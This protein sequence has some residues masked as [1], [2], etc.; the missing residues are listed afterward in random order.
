MN[1][2]QEDRAFIKFYQNEA[3]IEIR[4]EEDGYRILSGEM[5]SDI[6]KEIHDAL[7]N[8]NGLINA[9][10]GKILVIL[11]KYAKDESNGISDLIEVTVPFKSGLWSETANNFVIFDT[12]GSNSASNIDHAQVLKKAME[13]MSNGMPIFVSEYN[14]LDSTDNEKLY[15]DIKAI[16]ELDSRFTMIIVNKADEADLEEEEGRI[17]LPLNRERRLMNLAIP[18]NMFGEGVFFVSSVM[19]LGAKVDGKLINKHYLRLFSRNKDEYADP[20]DDLYQRLYRFNIMPEQLKNKAVEHAEKC[21]DLIYANSGLYSVEKEIQTFGDKYSSYNKCFQSETFLR[22]VIDI[23]SDEI[24]QSKEKREISKQNRLNALERDK[25]ELIEIID[26]QDKDSTKQFIDEYPGFMQEYIDEAKSTSYEESLL[27]EK[28]EYT[29][30]QEKELKLEDYVNNADEAAGAIFKNFKDS[31]KKAWVNKSFDEVKKAG[32]SFFDDLYSAQDQ[33]FELERVRQ[34][35]KEKSDDMIIEKKNNDY[36]KYSIYAQNS[37]NDH[38]K[39]YWDQKAKEIKNILSEIVTGSAALTEE[40]REK[41]SNIIISYQNIDFDSMQEDLI[42]KKKFEK[43]LFLGKMTVW[44][45]GE[46]NLKK[47]RDFYN[48]EI[49]LK[50]NKTYETVKESHKVSFQK[51]IDDLQETITVNIVEFNPELYSQNELI[52]E[53]TEK[54]H[55]LESRQITLN[56][57]RDEIGGKM[58]WKE[59]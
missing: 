8:N 28:E 55:E 39:E 20:M 53:E 17:G 47:L 18:K 27:D 46:V 10:M 6:V 26:K 43:G 16:E 15:K 59:G 35:I 13:D 24:Q 5:S 49:S 9:R 40:R 31:L 34:E 36:K 37:F 41:L 3:K 57:Y 23:T 52:K 21:K 11:E 48:E 4:L 32:N 42:D 54:I 44:S 12:P 7:E 45:S 22:K 19:G 50:I 25:K 38:S 56:E 33:D 29:A 58:K 30:I 51:W 14:S 2:K 1:S